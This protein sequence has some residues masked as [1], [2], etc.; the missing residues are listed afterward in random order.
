MTQQVC[1]TAQFLELTEALRVKGTDPIHRSRGPQI[2][3]IFD[4]LATS[5]RKSLDL[6][7]F[8]NSLEQLVKLRKALYL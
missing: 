4:Q 5:F 3:C 7:S 1:Y 8:E 2:A 6:L